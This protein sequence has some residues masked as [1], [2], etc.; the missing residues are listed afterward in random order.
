MGANGEPEILGSY[1]LLRGVGVCMREAER[2][3]V[4]GAMRGNFYFWKMLV[5]CCES[6]QMR[7][8]QTGD[9]WAMTTTCLLPAGLLYC[10]TDCL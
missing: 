4:W 1:A 3:G 7:N 5:G 9:A 2:G 10:G 8:T 6:F